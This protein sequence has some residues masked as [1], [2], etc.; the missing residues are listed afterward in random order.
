MEQTTANDRFEFDAGITFSESAPAGINY[1]FRIDIIINRTRVWNSSVTMTATD[2][3]SSDVRLISY[4]SKKFKT[5]M[6]N[7]KNKNFF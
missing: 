6:L 2:T 3:S 5:D 1:T 4:C 7:D